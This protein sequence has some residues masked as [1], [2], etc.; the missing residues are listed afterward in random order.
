MRGE[1]DTVCEKGQHSFTCSIYSNLNKFNLQ[2]VATCKLKALTCLM[3]GHD[4]NGLRM[5][6]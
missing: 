5:L 1:Q 6:T 2:H 4:N 3:V